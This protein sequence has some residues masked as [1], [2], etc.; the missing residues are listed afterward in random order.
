MTAE[1]RTVV[2]LPGLD[3]TGDLFQ[4]LVDTAPP[5]VRPLV[6]KLPHLGS[7]ADLLDAIRDQL[8]DGRFIILGESFSG[9]LALQIARELPERVTAVILCNSFVSRR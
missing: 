1:Y 3:G 5:D 9:P 4:P 8:P 6:V 7:Y 2:L